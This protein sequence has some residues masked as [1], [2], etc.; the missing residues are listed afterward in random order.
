MNDNQPGRRNLAVI[1]KIP[2]LERKREIVAKQAKE[3]M[4]EGRN[5]HSPPVN[6]PEPSHKE[7]RD[8]LA[9]EI[10]AWRQG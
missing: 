8:T 1:D 6:L 7:T 5:Q 10:G 3:R 4:E 2:L 9:A